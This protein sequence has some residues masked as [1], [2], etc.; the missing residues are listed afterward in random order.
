VRL[1]AR[2]PETRR[3]V[4]RL[5]DDPNAQ[6]RAAVLEM[7]RR[8]ARSPGDPA[9]L[10]LA[11]ER[12]DDRPTVRF[13]AVRATAE[14]GHGTVAPLLVPHLG[15]ASWWVRQAAEESL[16]ELGSQG[17]I[18]AAEALRSSEP[19]IRRGAA[20][21]LQETG[22]VDGLRANGEDALLERVFTAGDERVRL[23]AE[24][25]AEKVRS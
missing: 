9:A 6:V 21:V 19:E 7:L 22:V 10:R 14:L 5:G 15:D 13:Q 11:I 18:A 25:R 12:L 16:V 24:L 3:L 20:R 2:Y 23:T 8:T 4:A 17:A 1:L